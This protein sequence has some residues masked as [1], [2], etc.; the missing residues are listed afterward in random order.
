MMIDHHERGYKDNPLG[1]QPEWLWSRDLQSDRRDLEGRPGQ[2]AWT[3][4]KYFSILFQHRKFETLK[5]YQASPADAK[6]RALGT[7]GTYRGWCLSAISRSSRSRYPGR[8]RRCC[9][10]AVRSSAWTLGRPD[11]PRSRYPWR[12]VVCMP[13]WPASRFDWA[14][15]AGSPCCSHCSASRSRRGSRAIRPSRS[16]GTCGSAG[17]LAGQKRVSG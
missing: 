11:R 12:S 17:H 3:G 4:F 2:L 1:H 15:S 14:R 10:V 7:L 16:F 6:G 13:C 8:G 9:S 5:T